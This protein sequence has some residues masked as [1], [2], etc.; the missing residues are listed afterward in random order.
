MTLLQYYLLQKFRADQFTDFRALLGKLLS[1]TFTT[2]YLV[3]SGFSFCGQAV[4]GG[5]ILVLDGQT[6]VPILGTVLGFLE[7]EFVVHDDSLLLLFFEQGLAGLAQA[8][9][10]SVHLCGL[11]ANQRNAPDRT[12]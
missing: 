9:Q 8:G 6:D 7:E 4:H 3:A 12:L 2:E 11:D 5:V 1:L 10:V